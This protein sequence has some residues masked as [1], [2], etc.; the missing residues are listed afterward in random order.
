METPEKEVLATKADIEDKVDS[1]SDVDE[2][3]EPFSNDEDEDEMDIEEEKVMSAD[4]RETN[5]DEQ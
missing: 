3:V 5:K 4:E 2:E 1:E